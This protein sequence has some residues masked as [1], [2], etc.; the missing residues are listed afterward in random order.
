MRLKDQPVGT[1]IVPT[2]TEQMNGIVMR[3]FTL[4]GVP[5]SLEEAQ[6]IDGLCGYIRANGIGFEV[7][8]HPVLGDRKGRAR[9]IVGLLFNKAD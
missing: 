2:T 6:A 5:Y 4:H 3:G 1:F 9:P 8:P 7:S